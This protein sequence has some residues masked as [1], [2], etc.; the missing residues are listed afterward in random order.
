MEESIKN[1][2]EENSTTDNSLPPVRS[3]RDL[4]DRVT[5]RD[6]EI[7]QT[8]TDAGL[9]EVIPFPFLAL[10]GQDEM[11]LALLL[12]MINPHMGGVLLIGPRGTG[13]TTSV[14]SLPDL[15]P[16]VPRSLCYYGC[17]PDDIEAGGMDAV[18]PVCA[19]KYGEETPIST[20]DRVRLVELPLNARLDDVVGGLNERAATQGRIRLQRGILAKAD[21]NLLYVDEVNLLADDVVDA[22]LDAAAQGYYIVRR[23]AMSSTF[24]SRFVL[25]GSMNPE[26]GQLRPQIMDRFGLRV[27]VHGLE[28]VNQRLEAYRRSHNYA[29]NPRTVE[30]QYAYDTSLVRDEI[31]N[32]RDL[33]PEV[34]IPDDVA[35]LGLALIKDMR[36]DSLRAEITLFEAARAYAVADGRT[37]VVA[38]DIAAIGTMALRMRRSKFIEEYFS[39]RENEETE[40]RSMLQ[41]H[42]T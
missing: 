12:A 6:L 30:S 14:R 10:V 13:K 38:Q 33:L 39:Q 32:A 4:I 16:H 17:M 11:K 7:S 31:Q 28:S 42:I 18:C 19:K 21:L 36:V 37:E 20:Y 8:K 22:I 25:L 3:L 9:A 41:K 34:K 2:P 40:L 35:H 24:T 29:S 23:G 15:L 5:G 1:T 26:E 27:V